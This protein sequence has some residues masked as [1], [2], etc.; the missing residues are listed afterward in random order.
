MH[1]T[2]TSMC[3]LTAYRSVEVEV[4]GVREEEQVVIYGK[5]PDT[6]GRSRQYLRREEYQQDTV[7]QASGA[8][9]PIQVIVHTSLNSAQL[10]DSRI[11]RSR[12]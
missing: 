6:L 10:V 7:R 12:A 4:G 9:S 1:G 5:R 3:C 8:L 11:T 2:S